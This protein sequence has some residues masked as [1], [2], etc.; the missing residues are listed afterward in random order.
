MDSG[1]RIGEVAAEAGVNV[2][3]LRFYERR[4]LLKEPPRRASGYREY[5]VQ[6]VRM[7]R[8]IKR[9]QQLGF[10]LNEVGE[11]LSLRDS[12]GSSCADVRAAAQEKIA[13][14]ETKLESLQAIRDALKALV[15]TC[16][17]DG[18]A[19]ACPILE[20]LDN[21]PPPARSPAKSHRQSA[22][23]RV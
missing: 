15:K 22:Q 1:L 6:A 20:A 10:S 12:R 8:F 23:R 19:R 18:A 16:G 4:G 9:A 14:I 3:T 13:T 11:L 2:Q 7:I 5:P 21:A 17:R